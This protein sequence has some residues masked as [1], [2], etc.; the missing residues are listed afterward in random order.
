[1]S[2]AHVL[3]ATRAIC[4]VEIDRFCHDNGHPDCHAHWTVLPHSPCPSFLPLHT[5][6]GMTGELWLQE[7][8]AIEVA[9]AVIQSL[10][11]ELSANTVNAPMVAPEVL[12][13][14]QPFITLAR[15]LGKTAVQLV[16]ETGFTGAYH[17][18]HA[19]ACSSFCAVQGCRLFP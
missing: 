2:H 10:R 6:C 8:V 7:G 13:E 9:E 5:A 16:A 17:C 14:L 3:D 18:T 4:W 19:S 15:G 1:M 11:G 12:K